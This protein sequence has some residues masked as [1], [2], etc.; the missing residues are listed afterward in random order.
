MLSLTRKTDY[1]LVALALLGRRR[2]AGE[3]PVSARLVAEEFGLPQPLLM[4]I[5]KELAQAKI[6]TST[7]GATGG[8]TLANE[9]DQIT[10]LEVV[11]AIEG[12]VRLA[13]CCDG[14]PIAG[15]GCAVDA[16]HCPAKG[17]VRKLHQQIIRFFEEMTLQDLLDE[18]AD[19]P[20]Q[21]HAGHGSCCLSLSIAELGEK[22]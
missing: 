8:Y 12:P 9:P 17:A 18:A 14:L 5:L 21:E 20:E 13:Q 10:V 11:T 6:V 1:A 16:A 19:Q 3:G 15:Q 4:N 7:R 2:A 22:A